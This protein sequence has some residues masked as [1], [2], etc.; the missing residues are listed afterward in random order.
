MVVGCQDET[1]YS[2]APPGPAY[3][4]TAAGG[5]AFRQVTTGAHHS[6]GATR[7]GRGYCWG[8]GTYGQLGNDSISVSTGNYGD[9]IQPRPAAI[10]GGLR[11]REV[12][13]S[14]EYSCGVTMQHRAYCW[15]S[16]LFNQLGDGTNRRYVAHPVPVVGGLS[17]REVRPGGGHVCGVTTDNELYCWGFNEFGELGDGT[18][19]DRSSPVRVVGNYKWRTV[20]TGNAYT[21]AI[22]NGGVT[23]CWGINMRGQLGDG[24][25]SHSRAVPTR[26]AGEHKFSQVDAG[27]DHTCAVAV[28]GQAYCWGNGAYGALGDGTTNSSPRP[29]RVAGG[30]AFSRVSAGILDQ[31]SHTCGSTTSHQVYCWGLNR[32][33]KLGDGTTTTRLTPVAVRGGVVMLDVSA[34]YLHTC[35]VAPNGDA[36][37]WGGNQFS[38]LGDGTT[39]FSLTPVSVVGPD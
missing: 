15:G 30:L 10:A 36:Y 29:R 28:D 25:T 34:G 9:I 4:R 33:G 37:C 23:Y 1:T 3:S 17:F 38:E 11:F 20:T 19:T 39:T 5:L 35:G 21:C 16:N 22:A 13:A 14:W 24:S 7:D 2:T 12:V 8:W 6:C 31:G 18:R 26:V 32:T 27:F